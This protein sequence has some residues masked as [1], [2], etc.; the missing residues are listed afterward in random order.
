MDWNKQSTPGAYCLWK[1]S[2]VC[3][4]G[5]DREWTAVGW[6]LV[7]GAMVKLTNCAMKRNIKYIT[8]TV[9]D[10]NGLVAGG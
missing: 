2:V 7:G 6:K 3:A 9:E 10:S 5:E 4:D 1:L 8:T